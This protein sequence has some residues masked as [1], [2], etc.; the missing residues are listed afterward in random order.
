LYDQQF[1]VNSCS[2]LPLHERIGAQ[3][4]DLISK[5]TDHFSESR[6][7]RCGNPLS[8]QARIFDAKKP[9]QLPG[10]L[11]HFLSFFITFQVMAFADVSTGYKNAVS[12]FFKSL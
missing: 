5:I 1:P 2:G 8:T 9:H 10:L 11:Q 7:F 3:A 4:S 6:P 12:P